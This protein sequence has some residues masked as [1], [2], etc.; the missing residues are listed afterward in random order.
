MVFDSLDKD[1]ED[2]VSCV[3]SRQKGFKCWDNLL[4]SQLVDWIANDS[5]K[6]FHC[7]RRCILACCLDEQD[8]LVNLKM[9]AVLKD[10]FLNFV[11][12]GFTSFGV[13]LLHNIWVGYYDCWQI[14]KWE[15]IVRKPL[16]SLQNWFF[17][18]WLEHCIIVFKSQVIAFI[19]A[20]YSSANWCKFFRSHVFK[21]LGQDEV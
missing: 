16:F 19:N 12:Q 2:F 15:W 3:W 1:L 4:C 20:W 10:S 6:Q 5:I 9:V 17:K 18:E 7:N 21:V 11:F 8:G 14:I 13:E